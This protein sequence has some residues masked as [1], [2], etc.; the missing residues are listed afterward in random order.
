MLEGNLLAMGS[1]KN[2]Q[3]D[4]AR[5]SRYIGLSS[6]CKTD[7]NVNY[8]IIFSHCRIYLTNVPTYS[9]NVVQDVHSGYSTGV[10]GPGA[11]GGGGGGYG[12]G[13]YGHRK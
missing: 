6:W 5:H 11:F 10:V 13:G 8:K 12:G 3:Y 2:K 7:F 1:I 9:V 4:Q